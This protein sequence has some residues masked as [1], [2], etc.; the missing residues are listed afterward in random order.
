MF[1]VRK[2]KAALVLSGKTMHDLA[3]YLD[4]NDSTL[5]RKTNG[6]TEFTR[7]EIQEICRF[8]NLESPSEIFFDDEIA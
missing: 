8:L 7:K 6:I 3:V 5:Y 1:N 4:I 2:F